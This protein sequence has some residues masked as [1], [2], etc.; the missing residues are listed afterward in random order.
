MAARRLENPPTHDPRCGTYAG[1]SAHYVRREGAC[2]ECLEAGRA[3]RAAYKLTKGGKRSAEMTKAKQRAEMK[4]L[5]T[6]RKRHRAEYF[7]LY[8]M[9]LQ[10]EEVLWEKSA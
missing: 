9:M 5:R 10:E 6:L 2:D 4:A 1:I 8:N 7:N 3:Y